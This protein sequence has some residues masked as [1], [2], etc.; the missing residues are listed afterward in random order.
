MKRKQFTDQNII[1]GLLTNNKEVLAFLYD[2]NFESLNRKISS[3]GGSRKDSEDVFHDALL[4]LYLK[5]KK[6]NL[7]LTCSIHTFLQAIARNLW[8]R[9]I[10]SD[11]TRYTQIDNTL[12]TLSEEDEIEE[13]YIQVERRKLYIRHLLDMP[14]DC[15]RLIKM[16]VAGLSLQEITKLMA[17]NSVEYTKT[18]R[19]RCKLMLIKKI[20]NDPL[21]KELK[22]ERLGTPGEIPRW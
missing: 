13:E 4:I 12:E 8:K 2:Y 16:V 7:Q 15:Q 17:Y 19:F 21:Y 10:V 5:I 14:D 11:I 3:D 20:I 6:E 9:K 1:D 18:K 22:N